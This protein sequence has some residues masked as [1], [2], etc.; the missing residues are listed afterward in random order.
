LIRL[1]TNLDEKFCLAWKA[2]E[3]SPRLEATH[4]LLKTTRALSLWSQQAY[5]LGAATAGFSR[6]PSQNF[7]FTERLVY[8]YEFDDEFSIHCF[9]LKKD[10][11]SAAA[12]FKALQSAPPAQE[13]RIRQNY[14]FALKRPS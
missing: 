11:E 9:Y 3:F 10:K 7:L 2:L 13:A 6:T 14:E 4:E 8:D 5:A 12:A 1:S